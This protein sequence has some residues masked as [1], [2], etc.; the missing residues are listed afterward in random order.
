MPGSPHR[1]HFPSRVKNPGTPVRGCRFASSWA[2]CCLRQLAGKLSL[3]AVMTVSAQTLEEKVLIFLRKV[4]ADHTISSVNQALQAFHCSRRQL[5]R[6]LKKLCDEG[7]VVRTGRGCYR[8][9]E[10]PLP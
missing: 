6:V 2:I 3:S 7:L 8:L 9:K 5:Q 4:Q 10:R 1:F